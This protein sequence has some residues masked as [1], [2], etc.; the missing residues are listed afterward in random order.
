MFAWPR[1]RINDLC[2]YATTSESPVSGYTCTNNDVARRR[3]VTSETRCVRA[4]FSPDMF[5]VGA[6]YRRP[7]RASHIDDDVSEGGRDFGADFLNRRIADRVEA[8]VTIRMVIRLTENLPIFRVVIL[9]A[10]RLRVSIRVI[11][12]ARMNPCSGYPSQGPVSTWA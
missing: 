10:R 5:S 11:G 4:C 6:K 7:L 1:A 2:R 9:A 3:L 8:S 12:D